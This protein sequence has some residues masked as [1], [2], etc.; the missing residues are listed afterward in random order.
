MYS[1]AFPPLSVI[2]VRLGYPHMPKLLCT[3]SDVSGTYYIS[4]YLTAIFG[5][6]APPLS[7]AY[8]DPTPS[9]PHLVCYLCPPIHLWLSSSFWLG[10][11]YQFCCL[12]YTSLR[13]LAPSNYK[14]VPICFRWLSTLPNHFYCAPFHPLFLGLATSNSPS[15]DII[16]IKIS[17]PCTPVVIVNPGVSQNWY[18]SYFFIILHWISST[19]LLL[20]VCSD[21][22]WPFS[23]CL[24]VPINLRLLAHEHCIYN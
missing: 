5:R 19:F 21:F 13:V 23:I 15:L 20:Y 7:P 18:L 1:S 17:P 9:S 8:S 24:N 4:P 16:L 14:Q 22:A 11:P 6:L 2:L 10:Y 3:Y 12:S